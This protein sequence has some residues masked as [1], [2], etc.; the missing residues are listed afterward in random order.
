MTEQENADYLVKKLSPYFDIIM[1]DMT[2][3]P[4]FRIKGINAT[5]KTLFIDGLIRPKDYHNWK[6]GESTVFGID[7]KADM[8][9]KSFNYRTKLIVQA[10]DYRYTKWQ[11]GNRPPRYLPILM[12]P[13]PFDHEKM[14]QYSLS[15][16]FGGL[17]IGIITNTH[18][19]LEIQMS[20]TTIWSEKN[21]AT[22]SGLQHKFEHKIGSQ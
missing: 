15:R 9:D 7:L 5:G 3:D 2:K 21:G 13:N 20:E 18:R 11:W 4:P 12:F 8:S 6:N 17:N 19:G 1:E 16:I 10:I 22:G 14:D